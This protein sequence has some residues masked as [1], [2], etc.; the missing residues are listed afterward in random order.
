MRPFEAHHHRDAPSVH[1]LSQRRS[2]T[3]WPQIKNGDIYG[4]SADVK[5]QLSRSR[6]ANDFT[7]PEIMLALGSHFARG[8]SIASDPFPERLLSPSFVESAH[9]SWYRRV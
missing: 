2:Y 6:P 5:A 1:T 3:K 4:P 7:A 9:H 8:G